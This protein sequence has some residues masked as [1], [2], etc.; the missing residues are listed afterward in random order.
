M[1]PEIELASRP[2]AETHPAATRSRGS[3][4]ALPRP[5]S[6]DARV[7]DLGRTADVSLARA[8]SLVAE[9]SPRYERASR[10]VNV[11]LA[12]ISLVLLSP[13]FLA[14]AIAI[15]LT[16]R[17]PVLYLQPRVGMNRRGRRTDTSYDR[18]ARDLGGAIF[19]IYKFRSMRVDAEKESG[20]VWATKVDSRVTALGRFLRTTRLDELPQLINV[21]RGDMNIVGPRPDRPGIFARLRDDIAEYPLRQFA[22]PGITGWAQVNQPYDSCV[23]DVRRKVQYDL[24]YLRRRSVVEDLARMAKTLPVM[25]FHRSGW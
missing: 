8:P 22:R 18:R 3:R 23:D 10:A 15:K 21:L 14:I 9:A 17:G 13:L 2:A 24:E 16:S 4:P 1:T 20:A 25:L 7:L 19:M 5:S 6:G 12:A 11:M